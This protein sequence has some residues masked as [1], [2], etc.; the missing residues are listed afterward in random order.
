M[1][2]NL[3]RIAQDKAREMLEDVNSRP[4]VETLERL[5]TKSLGVLQEHGVYAL[6]LFLFS[7]TS[8]EKE[9]APFT[10][11]ALYRALLETPNFRN[12]NNHNQRLSSFIN[13]N[14]NPIEVMQWFSDNISADLN[15]LLL[16]RDLF[17]Q[18]LIYARYHAKAKAQE[19]GGGN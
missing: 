6:V 13:D 17:E 14:T 9:V 7:R 8:K 11:K 18:L 10:R 3:D 19:D 12:N 15:T 2:L 16:V 5:I 1:S 4:H